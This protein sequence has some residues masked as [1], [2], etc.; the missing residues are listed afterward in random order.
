MKQRIVISSFLL[1]VCYWQ[2][3]C[4]ILHFKGLRAR[5]SF[6]IMAVTSRNLDPSEVYGKYIFM[7][8]PSTLMPHPSKPVCKRFILLLM[9]TTKTSDL[10]F[11]FWCSLSPAFCISLRGSYLRQQNLCCVVLQPPSESSCRLVSRC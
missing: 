6:V 2:L 10:A 11:F 7:L 3:N 1:E 5:P 8:F 9:D 4:P